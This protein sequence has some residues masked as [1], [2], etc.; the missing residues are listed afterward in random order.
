VYG[1]L[2]AVRDEEIIVGEVFVPSTQG[3]VEHVEALLSALRE[4]EL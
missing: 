2:V 3:A 1:V 4:V